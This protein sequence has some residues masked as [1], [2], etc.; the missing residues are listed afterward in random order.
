[1]TMHADPWRP[2]NECSLTAARLRA[3][4]TAARPL[5][6]RKAALTCGFSAARGLRP[7]D[8]GPTHAGAPLKTQSDLRFQCGPQRGPT[9]ARPP[10]TTAAPPYRGR[11]RG[12][13][14]PAGTA[15]DLMDGS[16]SSSTSWTVA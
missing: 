5:R 4:V 16:G 1:M 7:E 10:S 6:G 14:I 13:A 8:C 3:A 2:A 12:A 15:V 11:G 9:A